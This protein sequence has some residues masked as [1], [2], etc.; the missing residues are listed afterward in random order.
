MTAIKYPPDAPT[1]PKIKSVHCRK[2]YSLKFGISS[3]PTH[4]YI[5]YSVSS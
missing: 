1:I 2:D 4:R 3:Y 5:G